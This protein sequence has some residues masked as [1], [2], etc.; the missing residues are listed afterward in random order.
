LVADQDE[1]F[2]RKVYRRIDSELSGFSVASAFDGEEAVWMLRKFQAS[3]SCDRLVVVA[4]FHLLRRT[5]LDLCRF[6]R[7]QPSLAAIP[8]LMVG[9]EGDP[10]ELC[11]ASL[12]AGADDFL[13]KPFSAREF[14]ARVGALWRRVERHIRKDRDFPFDRV[15]TGKLIVDTQ[16]YEVRVSGEVVHLSHKEF[17][18][19]VVLVSKMGLAVRHEEFFQSVWGESSQVG[20]ENLKVHIHSL[21][22]KL[23]DEIVIE[24]IRGVGYR[25]R[26]G[27]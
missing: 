16:K 3:K 7:S 21:R 23:G 12:E 27:P 9:G 6:V 26:V 5:G 11:L 25:L 24:A 22:A 4:D 1:A 18:V 17:L 10:H 19:C 14:E 2:H 20:K 8:F 15:Q 13:P